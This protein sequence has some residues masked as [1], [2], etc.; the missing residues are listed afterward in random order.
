[1]GRLDNKVAI[2]TG[3]GAGQGEAE[4]YLFAKEGAKVIAT[5]IQYES[6]QAVVERINEKYPGSATALK[7]D[8]S[9]EEDWEKVVKT[10]IELY[11]KVDILVNNAGIAAIKPFNETTVE[12]WTL[13]Q[14]INAWSQFVGIKT[15]VPYM[16]ENRGGSIVNIGSM[17]SERHSAGGFNAYTASKGA[18]KSLT[19]AAAVEFA[20]DQIRINLIQPGPILTNIVSNT[21]SEKQIEERAQEIPIKRLGVSEEI[22]NMALFL[23]SDDASYITGADH[24]VDGG[25]SVK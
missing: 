11:G 13:A 8:V 23:A 17:A 6:V 19:R 3:A 9:S 16:K 10:S 4:A 7:Q 12:Y 22:A 1:M 18:I 25:L 20:P 2:I 24:I 14:N 21:L 5:D 15:I